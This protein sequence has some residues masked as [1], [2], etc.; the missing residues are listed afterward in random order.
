MLFIFVT[1][2]SA[3]WT[4]PPGSTVPIARPSPH[5][6]QAKPQA[7]CTLSPFTLRSTCSCIFSQNRTLPDTHYHSNNSPQYELVLL[8]TCSLKINKYIGPS[9]LC[10]CQ[11]TFDMAYEIGGSLSIRNVLNLTPLTLAAKLARI[12]MFFHILNIEREIY[13]QIGKRIYG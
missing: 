9:F 13:W 4:L 12:E 8:V 10:A 3:P 1:N 2:F 11:S 6:S 7:V 5:P